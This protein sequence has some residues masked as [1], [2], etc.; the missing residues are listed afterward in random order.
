MKADEKEP[1]KSSH[2]TCTI[3]NDDNVSDDDYDDY[4]DDTVFIENDLNVSDDDTDDYDDDDKV[5]EEFF[6]QFQHPPGVY[7]VIFGKYDNTDENKGVETE[8]V[9]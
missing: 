2:E 1:K 9:N 5:I 7:K 6:A 3:K 4:D 8:E